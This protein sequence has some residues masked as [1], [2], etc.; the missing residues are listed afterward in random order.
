MQRINET[1]DPALRS[2]VESANS[3]DADFPLQ[4]LPFGVFRRHGSDEPFRGGVAIGDQIVDLA[5][6]QKAGAFAGDGAAAA[7]TC[8]QSTL[9]AF[10]AL[11]PEAWSALRLALSRALRLG[12]PEAATLGAC[13]V[14]QSEA[15]YAVPAQIG[16][17]TDFYTSV[18]H[19]TNVGRLF[20]PDNPLLPNYKWVPIGYHGRASTIGV[21][22]QTFPRPVGQ[23]M[24]PGA[25][26]PDFGPSKRLDYELEVG[27]FVGVGN[28][29]GE[30]IAL[31]EAERHVFGL[32]LLNDWSARDIQAW[33]YQPLG[34]FLSK[35]FAST[36]SP[37]IITLEAL[38]PYRLAWTRAEG[39]PQPLAYLDSPDTR[40][41]GAID[42]Q[43]EVALET[44]AMGRERHPATR[45]ACTSFKH[46]YWTVSQMVTHHTVNGCGLKPG[47]LLGSGTESGPTPEEA[48]SL[49]ELTVGGKQPVQLPNGE[50][51]TFLEDGDTVILRAW[52][53]KPGAAR[54][55]FGE[56]RSTVLP[57]IPW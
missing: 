50:T 17:Y 4:N 19:A 47:D 14:P 24:A 8:G 36:I 33:E 3:P 32:C 22:G 56:C 43:L 16:D 55:G 23:T 27:V 28:N 7:T 13:L 11:G 39:D 41:R 20:R 29:R 5:A 40:E 35:N 30:R 12:A 1:H 10:M 38:A 48:G 52:C 25:Q 26:T 51:R 44:E 15:E 45:L 6:A 37:W 53:E 49:L 18:H 9:N 46:S 31:Q 54:I 42:I 21:S 34:P 57:A 2:W